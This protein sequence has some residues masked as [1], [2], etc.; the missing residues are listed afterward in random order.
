MIRSNR[1]F[2]YEIRD[3]FKARQS[4]LGLGMRKAR[5]EAGAHRVPHHHRDDRDDRGRRGTAGDLGSAGHDHDIDRQPD[6][7]GRDLGDARGPSQGARR[8]ALSAPT[9]DQGASTAHTS[10]WR[11]PP[12]RVYEVV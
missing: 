1:P 6:E 5:H 9:C 12:A 3:G 8:R 10:V 4:C 7:L 2:V 11:A